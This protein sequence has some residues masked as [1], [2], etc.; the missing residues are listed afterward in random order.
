MSI[1]FWRHTWLGIALILAPVLSAGVVDAKTVV[2]SFEGTLTGVTLSYNNTTLQ[3][4]P[5][6]QTPEELAPAFF[7]ATRCRIRPERRKHD[8]PSW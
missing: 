3:F 2:F 6:V 5:D 8:R 4:A 1:L 7:P